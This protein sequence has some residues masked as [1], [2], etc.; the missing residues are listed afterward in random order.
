MN[1][2]HASMGARDIDGVMT[3]MKPR[4]CVQAGGNCGVWPWHLATKFEFVY[5]FEPDHCNFVAL[6]FNLR[7]RL[8]VVKMQAALGDIAGVMVN[9]MLPAHE[10]D[11][12]GAT[13]VEHGGIVP[14]IRIDDLK[15]PALDLLY[16][17]IEGFELPALKGAMQTITKFRPVIAIEDK[18]LSERYGVK[19]G[20]AVEW[21]CGTF[22][23]KVLKRVKRD[24]ILGHASL[25]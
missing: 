24:V 11:N 9:T 18:G 7:G 22:E 4:V 25:V 1:I 2:V 10:Q 17:D 12:C 20:E 8:N 6:A 23:Y 21:I 16:L 14:V 3:P 13:C 5:T 19:Q 15:L